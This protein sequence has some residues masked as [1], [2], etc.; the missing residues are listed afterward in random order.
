MQTTKIPKLNKLIE[1]S[2]FDYVNSN[3]KD[4]FFSTP[5]DIWDDYKLYHFDRYISSENAIKEMNKDGYIPANA[6]ELLLWKD[7]NEKDWVVAL[8][9]VGKV[10]GGRGVP[11]LGEGGS[12]RGL[13][14]G[15]WDLGWDPGYRFLAVRNLSSDTQTSEKPLDT[16]T[17]GSK[18][19]DII[20]HCIELKAHADRIIELLK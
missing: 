15:W 13:D 18:K 1:D 2:K 16:L 19:D 7:W 9:S 8:G 3:I 4:G 17:L 14:L 10:G 11:C 5:D 12:L 6:W 20:N